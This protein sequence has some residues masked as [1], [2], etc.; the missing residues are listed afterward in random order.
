MRVLRTFFWAAVLAGGFIYITGGTR[1]DV[2]QALRPVRT[3][4]RLWSEPATAPIGRFF[5]RRAEQ[6][7]YLQI[8]ARC[9]CIYH[10][11]RIYP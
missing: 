6:Y 5:H 11:H 1:W 9:H 4:G 3:A 2:G 8:G 10:V 7:R